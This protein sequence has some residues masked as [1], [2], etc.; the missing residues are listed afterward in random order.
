MSTKYAEIPFQNNDQFKKSNQENPFKATKKVL[1]VKMQ[2][3]EKDQLLSIT[4]ASM[5]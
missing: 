2:A 3:D 5:A 4:N 1:R